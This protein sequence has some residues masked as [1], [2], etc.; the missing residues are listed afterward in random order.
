MV[1]VIENSWSDDGKYDSDHITAN[2]DDPSS[3]KIETVVEGGHKFTSCQCYCCD[4]AFQL[5]RVERD[6]QQLKNRAK[7]RDGNGN[8][9]QY[10]TRTHAKGNEKNESHEIGSDVIIIGDSIVKNIQPRKLTRKKVHKY[11]FPGKT[12][13]EIEIEKEINFD[14]LKPIPSH[15]IIHVGTNNL[16][17]ESATE[18]AQKIEKL[19]KKTK[20]QF[21]Y[22]K[23][24]L[25]GLTMRHDIAMLEKI[26]E[27]NK[28]IGHIC[29]KLEISFIDNSTIDDTCLNGSK[30]HLNAKGSA[31]LVV[32]FI[33]FLKG[34]SAS[35]SPRKQRH[36]DFPRS[37]IQK[38]GELLEVIVQPQKNIHRRKN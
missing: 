17:L 31:I 20:T 25:S 23:I 35:V 3:S 7:T 30:L 38:L 14:N 6:I 15:V 11:T 28:K 8:T 21:P 27:V 32:H 33:N 19:A 29:K 10:A 36:Q 1:E 4:L 24:G 9:K 13:G 34:G 12:A 18:C 16:P 2:Q 22:S 26:Q 37:T 5:K